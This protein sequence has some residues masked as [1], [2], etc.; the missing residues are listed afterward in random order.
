MHDDIQ[1]LLHKQLFEFFRPDGFGVEILERF[2]LILIGHC[3]DYLHLVLRP[4]SIGF[5]ICD[6]HM[7]LCDCELGLAGADVDDSWLGLLS[8]LH[9][10]MVD[11]VGDRLGVKDVLYGSWIVVDVICM[12]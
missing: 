2:R 4:R 5:Q 10:L 9:A 11:H 3:V 12:V 1:L 8:G 7:H 6:D